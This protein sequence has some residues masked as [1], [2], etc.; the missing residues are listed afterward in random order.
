MRIPQPNG[1]KGSLKW[2]QRAVAAR[3]DLLQP[4]GLPPLTWVSPLAEDDFAEYRDGAFLDKLGLS[5]FNAD[6]AG[7]W[8]M[9]GPQWDGL[10]R[11]DDGVIL[12]EAKAHL[13]E[14]DTPPS[15]A[16]ARSAKQI[17]HAFAKV[18]ASLGVNAQPWRQVRYQYANR[19]AHLWWLRQLGVNA[20]LLFVSFLGDS[21]MPGSAS[22]E[23]WRAAYDLADREL[24]LSRD[25]G[26]VAH[27]HH[28][29]VEVAPLQQT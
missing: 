4:E 23:D 19:L 9:R 14:F 10:A 22:K 24:G 13:R 5:K 11:F 15:A 7:F 17:D 8:P 1:T 25:H 26:L 12:A 20:H 27:V 6:L 28:R 3:P 29:F 2:M 16:G 21:E 18:Q